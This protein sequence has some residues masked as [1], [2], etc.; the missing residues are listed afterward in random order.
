MHVHHKTTS[1]KER[2]LPSM[3]R[4]LSALLAILT[5][6][7]AFPLSA[8]AAS[9]KPAASG[10]S[11]SYKSVYNDESL[12]VTVDLS[13]LSLCDKVTVTVGSQSKTVIPTTKTRPIRQTAKVTFPAY[14]FN[15]GKYTVK[16]TARNTS[17]STTKTIGTVTIKNT[18]TVSSKILTVKGVKMS[19]YKI[20][21]KYT[22]SRYVS[23]NGKT[24]DVA[25]WQCCGYARYLQQKLYGRNSG[26]S[27]SYFTKL[28]GSKNV[29]MKGAKLKALIQRAGIGA[30]IRTVNGHSLVIIGIT[31]SGFVIADANADNKNTIRTKSYTYENFCKSWG[32]ISYIEVY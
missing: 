19:E 31:Y 4:T 16:V 3:K 30:H 27:K 14:T 22:S 24:V 11:T 2:S 7:F 6:I 21:S 17:G 32:T 15:P 20:G 23:V 18:Y 10:I 13:S 29:N 26:T 25:G 12:V 1:T 28:S 8:N 5:L 9:P